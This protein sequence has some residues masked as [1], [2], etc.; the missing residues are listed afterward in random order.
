M[1]VQTVSVNN[2]LVQI[3]SALAWKEHEAADPH[4]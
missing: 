4:T 1:E 2:E 3:S